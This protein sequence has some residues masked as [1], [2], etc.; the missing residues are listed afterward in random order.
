MLASRHA[1]I[2][3]ADKNPTKPTAEV[4]RGW[5]LETSGEQSR[6]MCCK[7]P[8]LSAGGM[9]I[10]RPSSAARMLSCSGLPALE[11]YSKWGSITLDQLVSG[12]KVERGVKVHQ[13]LSKA[14]IL[15]GHF[16]NHH[17][18]L[19]MHALNLWTYVM[20]HVAQTL[21]CSLAT[22]CET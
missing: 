22:P 15:R 21:L 10:E 5:K 7:I 17:H 18:A 3:G 12:V 6:Y 20:A 8:A 13:R 1:I 16:F 14:I 2:S 11:L 9:W 19:W 4:S